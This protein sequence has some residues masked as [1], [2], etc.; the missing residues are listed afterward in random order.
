MS[1]YDAVSVANMA[2][3]RIG[4]GQ[5][6]DDLAADSD[7]ARVCNRWYEKCRDKVLALGVFPVTRRVIALGLVEE[8]PDDGE[9]WA[10][11]YR[12]PIDCLRV[13]R[14]FNGL[15]VDTVPV[16]WEMGSDDTGR[17]IFT[18]EEDAKVEYLHLFSD[19]G[20]W[21]DLLCDAVAGLLASEI[22]IPLG[23]GADMANRGAALFTEAK[24]SAL[25]AA[26]REGF[27]RR[28]TSSYIT[29]RGVARDDRCFDLT[30]G[31]AWQ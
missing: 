28:P 2:L 12:Y 10:Y 8:N 15:R 30:R 11:S 5:P 14:I 29:A 1:V 18:D 13:L 3:D 4:I 16:E 25:A 27:L 9:K 24:A 23:R 26:Q 31:S 6:I 20:E 19:T 22:A 17:L 21:N 7:E